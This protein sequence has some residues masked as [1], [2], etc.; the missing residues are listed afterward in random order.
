MALQS[1]SAAVWKDV[2]EGKQ[3]SQG[4]GRSAPQ[5]ELALGPLEEGACFLG[6]PALE[7]RALRVQVVGR[8]HGS[9]DVW[10]DPTRRDR[11][12]KPVGV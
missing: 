4:A 3:N 5:Q 12:K 8:Q 9:H 2:S 1:Q 11:G 7:P 10:G 6:K